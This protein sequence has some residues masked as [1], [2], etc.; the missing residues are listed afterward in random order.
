MTITAIALIAVAMGLSILAPALAQGSSGQAPLFVD[1]RGRGI[2]TDEK[3]NQP[4][5]C[6]VVV[7]TNNNGQC[8]PTDTVIMMPEKI[9]RT[10]P[11]C[12]GLR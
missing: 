9:R 10:L 2:C 7:D 1:P 12:G 5:L 11:L 6:P 4:V 8:D 3:S